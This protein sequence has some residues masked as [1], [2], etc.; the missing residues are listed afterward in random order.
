MAEAIDPVVYG[1]IMTSNSRKSTLW[2]G[3]TPDRQ[4]PQPADNDY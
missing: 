4:L 1:Q 2:S 3:N